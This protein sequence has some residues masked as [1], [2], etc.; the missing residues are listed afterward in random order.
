C[1]LQQQREVVG[2]FT[3]RRFVSGAAVGVLQSDER[4]T[5]CSRVT[6]PVVGEVQA[7]RSLKVECGYVVFTCRIHPTLESQVA[8][9]VSDRRTF[10]SRTSGSASEVS[11]TAVN[12]SALGYRSNS[13]AVAWANFV[14]T[15]L[16]TCRGWDRTRSSR[17]R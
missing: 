6:V 9:E 1:E 5:P 12:T 16:R 7:T 11:S 14:T 17:A 4:H 2:K 10:L 13:D 15:V 3:F 8:N